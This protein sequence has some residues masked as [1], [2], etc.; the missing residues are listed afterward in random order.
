MTGSLDQFAVDEARWR[1]ALERE[2]PGYLISPNGGN[3]Y[4][5]RRDGTGDAI[6]AMTPAR[7]HRALQAAPH[8]SAS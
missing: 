1:E 4:A 8:R 6:I 5:N 7:L 2:W 3:W